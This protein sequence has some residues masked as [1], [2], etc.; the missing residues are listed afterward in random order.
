MHEIGWSLLKMHVFKKGNKPNFQDIVLSCISEFF[1]DRNCSGNGATSSTRPWCNACEICAKISSFRVPKIARGARQ[2]NKNLSVTSNLSPLWKESLLTHFSKSEPRTS[3]SLPAI[4]CI[5]KYSSYSNSLPNL[6][7]IG[8][9]LAYLWSGQVSFVS[10]FEI[11]SK[12]SH[13]CLGSFSAVSTNFSILSSLSGRIR[14]HLD[15]EAQN[16]RSIH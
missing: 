10:L 16:F 15:P 9:D 2:Y 3:Q 8:A 6:S 5:F 12:I 14:S 11:S 1:S 4:D 7:P 13:F